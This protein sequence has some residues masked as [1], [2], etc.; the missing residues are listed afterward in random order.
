[1][2]PIHFQNRRHGCSY[3]V[4]KVLYFLNYQKE[5]APF[6]TI[7]QPNPILKYQVYSIRNKAEKSAEKDCLHLY[8]FKEIGLVLHVIWS[9][10]T[11]LVNVIIN[12]MEYSVYSYENHKRNPLKRCCDVK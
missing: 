1:M 3:A 12:Q 4:K 2:P 9:P 7:T 5:T 10:F 6:L 8:V 11:L